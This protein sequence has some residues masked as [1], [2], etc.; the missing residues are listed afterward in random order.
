M[1][2]K[3]SLTKYIDKINFCT[4]KH[5]YTKLVKFFP[6]QRELKSLEAQVI[7][8]KHNLSTYI[9]VGKALIEE[10]GCSLVKIN[11]VAYKPFKLALWELISKLITSQN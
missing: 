9:H 3:V 5:G 1:L 11:N 4:F 6:T 8:S 2:T 7:R 10:N